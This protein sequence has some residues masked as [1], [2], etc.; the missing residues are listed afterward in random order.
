MRVPGKTG[1]MSDIPRGKFIG[2]KVG[3]VPS[4]EAE[5]FMRWQ[6]AELDAIDAWRVKQEGSPSR[7]AAIRR[8]AE[9]GL[10]RAAP[11][12]RQPSKANRRKATELADREIDRVLSDQPVTGEEKATRKRRLIKG[13]KEF[14]DMRRK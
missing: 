2:E 10:I 12:P 6:A 8:L 1:Q 4:N 14:R 3:G 11:A 13:L 7:S 9:L 5:H